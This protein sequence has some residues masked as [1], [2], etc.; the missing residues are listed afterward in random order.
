MRTVKCDR[1]GVTYDLSDEDNA[2]EIRQKLIYFIVG[3]DRNADEPEQRVEQS[4]DTDLC[5]KCQE[6]LQAVYSTAVI[7][8]TAHVDKWIKG[9]LSDENS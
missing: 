4:V 7:K 5:L 8:A 6:E 9:E 2:D 1:C 3:S